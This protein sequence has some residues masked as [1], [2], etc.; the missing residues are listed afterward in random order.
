MTT[1]ITFVD[2]DVHKN[3]IAIAFAG[4]SRDN[5]VRYY[6]SI[7]GELAPLD[8]VVRK[9]VSQGKT[10]SFVYEAGPCGYEIYRHLRRQGDDCI[11][12]APSLIRS[13]SAS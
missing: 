1:T 5:A 11:V 9:L 12:V 2:L 7:E 6:G 3:S 10:L 8:K 13:L 4:S